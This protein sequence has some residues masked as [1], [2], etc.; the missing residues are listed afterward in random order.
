MPA[1]TAGRS[2]QRGG[3]HSP[4]T[5]TSYELEGSLG[6]LSF[7]ATCSSQNCRQP[8]SQ[9]PPEGDA[10]CMLWAQAV[11]A[12]PAARARVMLCATWGGGS[13]GAARTGPQHRP[14]WGSSHT[15]RA[16]GCV[17]WIPKPQPAPV[18]QASPS[19]HTS[20]SLAVAPPR[21][22]GTALRMPGLGTAACVATRPGRRRR[23]H[24]ASGCGGGYSPDGEGA[25]ADVIPIVICR[26]GLVQDPL[27]AGVLP[28][29][30]PVANL[31]GRGGGERR[32]AG[33]A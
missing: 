12:A 29:V 16:A 22:G 4:S 6:P 24:T 15:C 23:A 31:E 2:T 21:A 5:P 17:A 14:R 3:G 20:S 13:P 19:S 10:R 26:P 32:Q 7:H 9:Y 1:R 8:S 27:V 28:T 25:L 33:G 18:P 11:R 30:A